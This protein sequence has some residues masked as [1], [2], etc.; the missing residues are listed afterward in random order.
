MQCLPPLPVVVSSL[1]PSTT[2]VRPPLW[3]PYALHT[4]L[5]LCNLC[6]TH[7]E[8]SW[9]TCVTHVSRLGSELSPF[10]TTSE[11][12]SKRAIYDEMWG[13]DEFRQCNPDVLCC[14]IFGRAV[15]EQWGYAIK[16]WFLIAGEIWTRD[17]KMLWRRVQL[18]E[19]PYWWGGCACCWWRKGSRTVRSLPPVLYFDVSF[20][21][22]LHLLNFEGTWYSMG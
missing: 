14:T 13:S 19:H 3:D 8:P 10:W 11:W 21:Y 4:P 7:F 12:P 1:L 9:V 22:T 2:E 5:E 17:G 16:I 18:E 6:V 20:K 15:G